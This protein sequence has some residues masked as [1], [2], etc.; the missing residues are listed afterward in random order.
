MLA[1]QIGNGNAGLMLL[2]NAN[3]LFFGESGLLHLWSFRL[4]QS[5]SQTG[6]NPGGNV[7]RYNSPPHAA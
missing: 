5:L 7:K 6:L 4:S 1:A 2:Q 3:D